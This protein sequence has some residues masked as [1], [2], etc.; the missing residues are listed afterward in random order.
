MALKHKG[1]EFEEIAWR[2]TEKDAIAFSG[3]GAVPVLVD[4]GRRCTTRGT[5]PCTSGRPTQPA[6]ALRG[7]RSQALA[8]FFNHWSVR[9]L[10][11]PLLRII[12]MDIFNRLADKDKAYYRETREKRFGTTWRAMPRT[13]KGARG[14]PRRARSG[15][16]GPRAERLRLRQGPGFADYILFGVFQWARVVSPARLLEPDDPLFAWRERMLDLFGSYARQAK[17]YAV[18]T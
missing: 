10:H 8:Q 7:R 4:G 11:P 16:P 18:W 3:Q 1:L 2:Y 6:G 14:A 15:A 5:S 12:L 9:T 13:R 17:G